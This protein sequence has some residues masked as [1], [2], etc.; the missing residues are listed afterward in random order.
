MKKSIRILF[1]ISII[2]AV[3]SSIISV[4]A[5]S[6]S[7]NSSDVNYD[8]S[9]SNLSSDNVQGALNE[10]YTSATDYSGLTSRVTTLESNMPTASSTNPEMD[11]TEAAGSS[12]DYARADHVHPSDTTKAN[13]ASPAFTGTP[14]AP[15]AAA[16][17]NTTQLATT[18]F[19]TTAVT[20]ATTNI[21]TEIYKTPLA[22]NT[23]TSTYK[24]VAE[25]SLSAGTWIIMGVAQFASNT[26]GRR[27]VFF[28]TTK[29]SSTDAGYA[30][31]K[32]TKPASG[33]VT[34]ARTYFQESL[35]STTTYYLNAWQNSGSALDI[36]G[37]IKA[38]RVK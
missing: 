23:A 15:T 34:L 8:N 33:G 38:V 6:Y 13:L 18:A 21:G 12:D 2:F 32:N 30:L 17:T 1:I 9:V 24:T 25:V 29:D 31:Q 11:G 37:R 7:Y 22:V 20:N 27:R 4:F 5:V 28:S 10:L 35:S 14:K 26:T 19:T 36:T 3:I 16:G